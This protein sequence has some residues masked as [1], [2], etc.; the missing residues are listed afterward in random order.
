MKHK[1]MEDFFK[2]I[3]EESILFGK[4]Y[5]SKINGAYTLNDG[6]IIIASIFDA[7]TKEL[8]KDMKFKHTYGGYQQAVSWCEKC[9]GE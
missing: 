4:K 6:K 5:I 9:I 8:L 2:D 3:G 1:T 7:N